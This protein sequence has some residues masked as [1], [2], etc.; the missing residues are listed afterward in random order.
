MMNN[1]NKHIDFESL[2]ASYLVGNASP[3]EADLLENWVKSDE[4]KRK[5]FIEIKR[6]WMLAST[7]KKTYNQELAW[8]KITSQTEKSTE[9]QIVRPLYPKASISI[10]LKIAAAITVLIVGMYSSYHFAYLRD[11]TLVAELKPDGIELIDG[12]KVTVNTGS[13]ITYPSRFSGKERRVVLKG[14]AFFE[15]AANP[16]KAFVVEVQGIEV[17][18]LGT[19][20]NIK[21]IPGNEAVEVSVITGRVSIV[22]ANMPELILTAGE[23]GIYRK[24]EDNLIKEEAINPN[25]ISWKTRQMV[26]ENTGLTEVFAVIESTYGV[27][28]KIRDVKLGNCKLTASFIDKPVDDVL[29]IISETFNLR[30]V[31]SEGAIWATGEGCE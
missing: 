11:K 9:K 30:Y 13:S 6:T 2:V 23:T 17:R 29:N 4:E 24:A 16:E 7:A 25:T 5:L 12:S 1:S 18:V 31:R 15:V 28:V 3:Q 8:K 19:S 22:A 21:S 10:V 26:F 20:F 14:E 27:Q